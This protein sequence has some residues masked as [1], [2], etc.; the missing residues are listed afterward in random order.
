MAGQGRCLELVRYR[1]LAVTWI[2]RCRGRRSGIVDLVNKW[3]RIHSTRLSW[4]ALGSMV[5]V[6][7]M[8]PSVSSWSMS[9]GI[10]RML[11]PTSEDAPS[12]WH[13]QRARR[14]CRCPWQVPLYGLGFVDI[15]NLSSGLLVQNL[16]DRYLF[17]SRSSHDKLT[18]DKCR[19]E[20][21][22]AGATSTKA[23]VACCICSL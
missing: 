17:I 20:L 10:S 16:Q 7:A 19:G 22:V 18:T 8:V 3:F 4:L 12:S 2:R 13:P 23:T 21:V 14:L 11:L 6:S 15:N 1:W 5:C 9:P